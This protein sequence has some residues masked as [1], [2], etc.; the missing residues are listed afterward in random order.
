MKPLFAEDGQGKHRQWT[1]EN[2]LER[3]KGIRRQ[4]VAVGAVEFDQVS[5]PDDEQQKILDLLKV[6][7]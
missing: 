4:R 3:L 5:Q 6:K 7:L 2:V 1:V